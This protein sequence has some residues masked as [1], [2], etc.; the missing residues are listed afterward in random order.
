VS[1]PD[2]LPSAD[3]TVASTAELSKEEVGEQVVQDTKR[4]VTEELKRKLEEHAP[5]IQEALDGASNQSTVLDKAAK[6][7]KAPESVTWSDNLTKFEPRNFSSDGLGPNPSADDLQRLEEAAELMLSRIRKEKG[8]KKVLVFIGVGTGNPSGGWGNNSVPDK[9]SISETDQRSPGFLAGAA[10]ED[11]FVIAANFNVGTGRITVTQD[12]KQ[13]LSLDVS[14]K[15]PLVDKTPGAEAALGK[16][17]AVAKAADRFAVMNAVTQ[18]DY[19]PLVELAQAKQNG[20]SAYLK[21]YMM[22]DKITSH[23]HMRGGQWI[24]PEN[25]SLK[26][27]QQ[28]FSAD[29]GE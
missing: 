9:T 23:S 25:T 16:M 22:T 17:K 19:Q 18:L 7:A 20:S 8:G 24:S 13:G 15:F 3:Q 21:S 6:K 4:E 14:A 12:T 26:S 28:V 29:Q 10:D 11:Y 5:E 1:I 27:M 2:G